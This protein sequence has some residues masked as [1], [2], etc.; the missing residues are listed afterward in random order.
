M[1]RGR[2]RGTEKFRDW[3]VAGSHDSEM[4]TWGVLGWTIYLATFCMMLQFLNLPAAGSGS[5]SWRT[6]TAGDT[7]ASLYLCLYVASPYGFYLGAQGFWDGYPEKK[8]QVEAVSPLSTSSGW[9]TRHFC[10]MLFIRSDSLNQSYSMGGN[11]HAT[12]WQVSKD[13][14]DTGKPSHKSKL[15]PWPSFWHIPSFSSSFLFFLPCVTECRTRR[16]ARRSL[17]PLLIFDSLPPLLHFYRGSTEAAEY[18][19][20]SP[21]L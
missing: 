13:C 15:D 19:S 12:S 6:Q 10:P 4:T 2:G 3:P 8:H 18:K 16:K 7:Q 1:G 17:L 14:G 21:S 9:Y 5:S 20:S 11:F